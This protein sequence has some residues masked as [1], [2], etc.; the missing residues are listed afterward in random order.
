ML[1]TRHETHDRE[2]FRKCGHQ[3]PKS[4]FTTHYQFKYLTGQ[5]LKTSIVCNFRAPRGGS[6][7][8]RCRNQGCKENTDADTAENVHFV[9]RLATYKY[10]NMDQVTAQALC[11][12]ET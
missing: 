7:G 6:S 1:W 12:H 10:Y 3:L 4:T 9:G 8:F 2:V 5:S 11:F